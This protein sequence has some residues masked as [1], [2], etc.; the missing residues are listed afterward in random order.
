MLRT[1]WLSEEDPPVYRWT[2]HR[3]FGSGE[4]LRFIM[5]NPSTADAL[6]D[7][8]TIVKCLGFATR[9]GFGSIDVVNLFPFRATKPTVMWA[10]QKDGVDIGGG[11]Q[12]KRHLQAALRA[13]NGL[14]IAAWGANV[15]N[16]HPRVRW[17]MEQEGADRLHCLSRT[18]R[19]EPCH[20]L[21]LPYSCIPIPWSARLDRCSCGYP[22]PTEASKN[23][24]ARVCPLQGRPRTNPT[25]GEGTP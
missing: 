15:R 3:V 22:T 6:K 2:L 20:P 25:C 11:V 12:G 10:A 19:G 9:L 1:A 8:P 4:C 7:D 13:P 24:H 5:L 23:A 17:L 21:M 18:K 16:D 14:T